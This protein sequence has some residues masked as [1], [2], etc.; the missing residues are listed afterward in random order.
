M[1]KT[2]KLFISLFFMECPIC[3]EKDE[4]KIALRTTFINQKIETIQICT[5]CLWEKIYSKETTNGNTLPGENKTE[6]QLL[7]EK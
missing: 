2:F 6:D 7:S 3:N 4:S 1:Y 5:S